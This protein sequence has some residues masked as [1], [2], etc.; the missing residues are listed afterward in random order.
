MNS[1]SLRAKGVEALASCPACLRGWRLHFNVRHFFRH[2]GGVGNIEFTGVPSD[3]V[4]GVL[5]RCTDEALVLLDAAEAYGYGYDRIFVE[6]ETSDAGKK[7]HRAATYVGMPS[8]ID[9]SCLP[10]RRY[11]NILTAGA[12]E[13]GLASGYIDALKKTKVQEQIVYPPFSPPLGDFPLFGAESLAKNPCCTALAGYVF[14][15]S[16]ATDR[17]TYLK[18]FFGGRDMTLFHLQRMDCSKGDECVEDIAAARYNASQ[19]A[20]LN[21]YLHEYSFEYRYAGKLDIKTGNLL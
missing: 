14:D 6:V 19:R 1:I 8:F 10:T 11:L 20:Y 15:M 18:Q 21:T 3:Y 7:L 9:N 16:G 17:H 5:H 13:A 4:L 12:K 2:E